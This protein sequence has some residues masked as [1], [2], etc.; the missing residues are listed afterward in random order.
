MF[1]QHYSLTVLIMTLLVSTFSSAQGMDHKKR[2]MNFYEAIAK[3]QPALFDNIIVED[4]VSHDV[5]PGQAEGSAG[6]K[7]FV[8]LIHQS[9]ADL[10]W[11]VEE[12]IQEGNT[13]VV[14]ST[15]SGRHVGPMLG[16]EATGKTFTA[17]AIDI[18]HFNSEG[19]VVE[20]YHLEDWIAFLAQVGAFK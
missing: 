12:M 5:N 17:K 3:N 10:T 19:L 15:F 13:V 14:R 20:T 2:L 8:P 6:I 4:W 1:K 9:I 18:H 7:Q 11:N 16:V